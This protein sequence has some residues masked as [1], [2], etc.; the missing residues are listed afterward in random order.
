MSFL[1]MGA[2]IIRS[3][4]NPV[5]EKTSSQIIF[6]TLPHRKINP[7]IETTLHKGPNPKRSIR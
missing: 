4:R 2:E 7:A 1:L 3:I 5:V 6:P